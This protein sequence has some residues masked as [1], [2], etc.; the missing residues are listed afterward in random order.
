MG[1][2]DGGHSG[3][4][5]G[6]MGDIQDCFPASVWVIPKRILNVPNPPRKP[7][8]KNAA[9]RHSLNQQEKTHLIF[10]HLTHMKVKPSFG[11]KSVGRAVPSQ[12]DYQIA[13]LDL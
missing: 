1:G 4:M 13:V 2:K 5:G 6:K 9:I 10:L 3:K 11:W 8:L 12:M 7:S